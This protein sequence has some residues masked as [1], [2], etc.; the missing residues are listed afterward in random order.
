MF[1]GNLLF[2]LNK[3]AFQ[4]YFDSKPQK[5]DAHLG[6]SQTSM[7]ERFVKI[8]DGRKPLTIF[9]NNFIAELQ[10]YD[11][12]LNTPLDL[13]FYHSRAIPYFNAV[14]KK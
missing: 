9:T 5:S 7:M 2:T 13:I 6:T 3:F 1:T 10:M 8:V 4:S 14:R 12:V 11:R